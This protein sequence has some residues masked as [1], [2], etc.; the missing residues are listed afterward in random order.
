MTWWFD[1]IERKHVLQNPT[2][3]DK[4]LLLGECLGLGSHSNVLDIGAGKAGPALVL[5]ENFGCRITCVEKSPEFVAAAREK[6][7]KA[8]LEQRITVVES[9]GRSFVIEPRAFDAVLCLGAS[10]IWGG[11]EPTVRA[12]VAGVRDGGFVVVGEPFWKRWPLP[13]DFEPNEGYDFVTLPETIEKLEIDGLELV[14]LIASSQDDWDRYESLHWDAL[15]EWLHD[16]P[17]H[18]DAAEFRDVGAEGRN[19]YLRWHRDLLGWGIFITR[20][21]V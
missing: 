18:P 7:Q 13:E 20:K 16:N 5:A 10:F 19:L 4:V 15:E 6:V 9:D 1:V 3:R 8:G 17:D 14:G 11:A 12:M 2:S 21:R